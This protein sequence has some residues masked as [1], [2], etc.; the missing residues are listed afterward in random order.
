MRIEYFLFLVYL[1]VYV[2]YI[3]RIS[4]VKKSGLS[5]QNIRLLFIAKMLIA[6]MAA[7]YYSFSPHSDYF[8]YNKE[9]FVQYELLTSNPSL[10]LQEFKRDIG[11][12]GLGN[13]FD[14]SNSFWGY[15]RFHLLYKVVAIFCFI[16]KGNMLLNAGLF[17]GLIFFANIAFYRIYDSLYTGKSFFKIAVC[18]FIP[19]TALFTACVGKDGIVFLALGISSYIFYSWLQ[20]NARLTITKAIVFIL[21]LTCIFLFRNYILIALLPAMCIA[22][23]VNR[24]NRN[25]LAAVICFY[26]A[27]TIAFFGTGLF[28]NSFNLP[29][30]VVKRKAEFA[31]IEKGGSNLNM[32]PLEPTILSFAKNAPQALN[33]VL[34]R[35]YPGEFS[36][37]GSLI[38]AMELYTYLLLIVACLWRYRKNI[39]DIHPFNVYALAFFISMIFIIGFTIPNAGA[40]IRYRSMLWVF[41]LTPVV[42][43]LFVYRKTN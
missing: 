27:A 16:T 8:L 23:L 36:T 38:G 14:A 37:I 9:G 13:I 4:F 21:A 10:F 12:Y 18:F 33:H 34:L 26:F 19:S 3:P 5:N 30:A 24:I 1:I 11:L 22:M 41:I 40:I 43:K 20:P 29:N 39:K 28:N 25:K 31:L 35:P 42:Y 15:L 32:Y 2:W 6:F 7:Y 17:S